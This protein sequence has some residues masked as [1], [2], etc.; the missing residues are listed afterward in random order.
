[1]LPRLN[2][3]SS[4]LT[5]FALCEMVKDWK[6]K[7]LP[8]LYKDS[9][10]ITRICSVFTPF[11]RPNRLMIH[12]LKLGA[13]WRTVATILRFGENPDRAHNV[14]MIRDPEAGYWLFDDS[15]LP[16]Y[17]TALNANLEDHTI[18]VLQKVVAFPDTQPVQHGGGKGLPLVTH[19]PPLDENAAASAGGSLADG[20]RR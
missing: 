8:I 3:F 15:A 11:V 20:M 4:P 16:E 12:F 7:D 18:L 1:M 6:I 13:R 14:A 19:I 2:I 5:L 10:L 9:T 17:K